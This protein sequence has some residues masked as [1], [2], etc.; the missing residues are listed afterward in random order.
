MAVLLADH[1]NRPIR[2]LS[3]GYQ[4][5]GSI[6]PVD[7]NSL[8]PSPVRFEVLDNGTLTG[9]YE[10]SVAGRHHLSI[11]VMERPLSRS[12][13]SVQV[14]AG[15]PDPRECSADGAGIQKA[16]LSS[17]ASFVVVLR[18]KFGN[19]RTT[20]GAAG[21]VGVQVSDPSSYQIPSD[22]HEAKAGRVEGSYRPASTGS[23]TVDV[24]VS[25]QSIRG[26]PFA[27]VV[28]SGPVASK[29]R[30][31]GPGIAQASAGKRT[32]FTVELVD[33]S[34]APVRAK[35]F[36]STHDIRLPD[37]AG[38]PQ[39]HNVSDDGEGRCKVDYMMTA[40]GIQPI[41]VLVGG[42]AIGGS[43]FQVR[44]APGTV[45]FGKST[46]RGGG[47]E[48]PFSLDSWHSCMCI[49]MHDRRHRL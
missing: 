45:E 3:G 9:S 29:C 20:P 14:E 17:T 33:D 26:A 8:R 41:E 18:D 40:A 39:D 2:G 23:H 25:G 36:M 1:N 10:V 38:K 47:L 37:N 13:F 15:P 30:A 44:V 22:V 35:G 4:V 6:A 46:A 48:V 27:V 7:N 16:Y 21:L 28:S 11:S 43:P 19:E 49:H 42:E 12:P 32:E 5:V 24:T 31:S 34:G